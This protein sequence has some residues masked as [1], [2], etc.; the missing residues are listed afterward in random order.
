MSVREPYRLYRPEPQVAGKPLAPREREIAELAARGLRDKEIAAQLGLTANSVKSR[1]QI[2]YK[3]LGVDN[4][5]K[6]ANLVRGGL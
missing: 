1:F 2:I 3:K 4:R 5:V 6:M